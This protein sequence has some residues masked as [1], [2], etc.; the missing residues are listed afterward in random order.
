MQL[1]TRI[2]KVTGRYKELTGKPF[3]K[4]PEQ[5]LILDQVIQELE[6]TISDLKQS[7]NPN[8][9]QL[10]RLQSMLIQQ[11]RNRN[12]LSRTLS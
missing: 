2:D 8:S 6:D 7:P 10:Q 3:S 11:K 12:M 9:L 1:V 4:V 5:I